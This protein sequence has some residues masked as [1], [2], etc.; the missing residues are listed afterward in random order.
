VAVA[1]CQPAGAVGGITQKGHASKP[2]L[3]AAER[4]EVALV[5]QAGEQGTAINHRPDVDVRALLRLAD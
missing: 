2:N 4:E 5:E 1:A 3:L